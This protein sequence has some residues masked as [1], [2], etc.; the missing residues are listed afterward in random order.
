MSTLTAIFEV[1]TCMIPFH[2]ILGLLLLVRGLRQ[3]YQNVRFSPHE[4]DSL[5][6]VHRFCRLS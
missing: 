2:F 3:Q 6:S 1:V 5:I 4:T